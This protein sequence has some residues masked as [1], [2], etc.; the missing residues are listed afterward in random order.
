MEHSSMKGNK[1]AAAILTVLTAAAVFT[2]QAGQQTGKVAR[3]HVRASD[4]L[5]YMVLTGPRT[6]S[7]ACAARDYWVIKNENSEAGKRQYAYLLTA[8]ASNRAITVFGANTCARWYDGED[9][10]AIENAVP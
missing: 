10:E 2:A 1:F 7:P 9:I 8:Q 3:I 4:G 5:I 6:G